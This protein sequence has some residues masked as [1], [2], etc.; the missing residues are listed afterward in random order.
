MTETGD[1]MENRSPAT[2]RAV[3]SDET[4]SKLAK[5]RTVKDRVWGYINLPPL[6]VAVMDTPEF[7]RLRNIKQLACL[8]HVYPGNS[9]LEL[10][11]LTKREVVL[12]CFL[13]T[14]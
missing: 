11:S 6:L 13:C 5:G 4:G 9:I 8:D 10:P 12:C 3:G 2:N 1:C 7:Q 14:I